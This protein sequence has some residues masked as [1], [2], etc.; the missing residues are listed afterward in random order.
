MDGAGDHS[1]RERAVAFMQSVTAGGLRLDQL[2]DERKASAR[3]SAPQASPFR[4]ADISLIRGAEHRR[5]A[6]PSLAES[7]DRLRGLPGAAARPVQRFPRRSYSPLS[8]SGDVG[9]GP[10]DDNRHGV[11][12]RPAGSRHGRAALKLSEAPSTAQSKCGCSSVLTSGPAPR[13]RTAR[14]QFDARK[15]ATPEVTTA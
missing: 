12:G 3:L 2:A 7:A 13:R 8:T 1:R 14:G 15:T 4:D 9:G 10:C 6:V 11:C 5:D